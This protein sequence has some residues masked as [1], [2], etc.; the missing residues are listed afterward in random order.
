[1]TW[2]KKRNRFPGLL[3]AVCSDWFGVFWMPGSIGLSC[4]HVR[5]STLPYPIASTSA[6]FPA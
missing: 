6:F 1:M 2:Q 4:A 5:A 3:R